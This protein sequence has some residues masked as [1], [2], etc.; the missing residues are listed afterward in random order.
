MLGDNGWN[1]DIVNA[2]S[3]VFLGRNNSDFN[4][5]NKVMME[6]IAIQYTSGSDID[7]DR[8][9]KIQECRIKRKEAIATAGCWYTPNMAPPITLASKT[10]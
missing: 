2:A 5:A 8:L 10:V 6:L 1:P 3:D 4:R 9:D 7:Q